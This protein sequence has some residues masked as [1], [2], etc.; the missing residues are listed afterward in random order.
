MLRRP[1]PFAFPVCSARPRQR[2]RVPVVS[3]GTVAVVDYAATSND[4]GRSAASPASLAD[5]SALAAAIRGAQRRDEGLGELFERLVGEVG[6]AE[7]S[8]L[9]FAVFS[10]SD[11]SET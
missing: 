8:R 3:D 4:G 9:W 7:A 1:V 10:A 2:S 5:A 11:A 6:R